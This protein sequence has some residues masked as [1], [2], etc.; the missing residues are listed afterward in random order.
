M[1][2]SILT[3]NLYAGIAD[4]LS[5]G[6]AGGN[7]S[8]NTFRGEL[9]IKSNLKL[10][11]QNSEMKIGLNNRSYEL[12]YDNL[13][14]LYASS[15]GF[16]CD[17]AIYPFNK[18]LFTGIRWEFIN[19]NSLSDNSK[20]KIESQR[21]YSPNSLYTGTCIFFQLGYLFNMSDNSGVRVFVQPGFHEFKIPTRSS[22]SGNYVLTN[23]TNDPFIENHYEFIYNI[24]L[25]VE[26][27]IN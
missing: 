19:F 22:S 2:I 7:S 8:Y 14:D 27:G 13:P 24:N 4:S 23:S 1:T 5:I 10:F 3:S 21:N 20:T 17:I 6:L 18:G 12:T 15:I 16:F 9:F 25:S 26:I 11:S